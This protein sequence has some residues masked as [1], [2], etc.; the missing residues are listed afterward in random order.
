MITDRCAGYCNCAGG[1]NYYDCGQCVLS[2]GDPTRIHPNCP[3]IGT[4]GDMYKTCCGN[5]A[6]CGTPLNGQC[7]WCAANNHA[8]FD[9]DI[10]TFN[11]VCG[12]QAYK[13]HCVLKQFVPY[14]CG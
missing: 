10:G 13:G 7:D 1:S 12:S 11:K 2:S 6:A 14:K 8:H 5:D 4:D 9:L 3:C